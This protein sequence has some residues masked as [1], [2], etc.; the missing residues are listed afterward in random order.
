MKRPLAFTE[1]KNIRVLPSGYQV[2]IVRAKI[3]FSRHFAGH[4]EE[5]YRAA[6]R[7]REKVLREL[8][9]KRLNQIPRP[10]LAA[11]GLREAV[12]GVFRH[13]GRSMYQVGYRENGQPRN[14]AFTWGAQRSEAEAYAAAVAFREKMIKGK[15]KRARSSRSQVRDRRSGSRRTGLPQNRSKVRS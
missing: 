3:E 9:P 6:I 11:A 1:F 8:P 2:S 4:S 15:T 13:A 10:V 7:F 14:R 5:S 12:V